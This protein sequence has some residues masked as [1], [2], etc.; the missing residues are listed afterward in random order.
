[1]TNGLSVVLRGSTFGTVVVGAE[2][3]AGAFVVV[4]AAVVDELEVDVV[5]A[6]ALTVKVPVRYVMV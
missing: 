2:V 6:A 4:G 1:M 3:V 5:A